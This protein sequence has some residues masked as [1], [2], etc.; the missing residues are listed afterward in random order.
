VG[1]YALD[2]NLYIRAFR[3]SQG[4]A[5]LRT[6]Y[7]AHTPATYLSSVVL[8]EL[9]IGVVSRDSAKQVEEVA[10][11]FED[12]ARIITPSHLAWRRSGAALSEIAKKNGLDRSR[13]P[14]SLVNDVLIAASCHEAGVTLVTDNS[15]D[16]KL[17]QSVLAFDFVPPWP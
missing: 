4:G 3:D 15:R 5:E 8:H 12:V 10:R 1:K 17:F 13:M 6:F 11:P 16:F 7:S 14:R 2:T 9:A